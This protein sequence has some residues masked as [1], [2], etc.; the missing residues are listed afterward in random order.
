MSKSNI[1]RPVHYLDSRLGWSVLSENQKEI[2]KFG[3]DGM[4]Q[5][6][7]SAIIN[8]VTHFAKNTISISIDGGATW[9]SDSSMWSVY[10][11][12][13]NKLGDYYDRNGPLNKAIIHNLEAWKAERRRK[14]DKERR[15]AFKALA[16]EVQ[17][18]VRQERTAAWEKRKELAAERKAQ[19]TA[20]I[21]GQMLEIGPELVR[22]KEEIDRALALMAKGGLDSQ[23]PY[24]VSRRRYIRTAKWTVEDLS[25]HIN[26]A[27]KRTNK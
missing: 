24:Y 15:E 22:L 8:H 20:L 12:N 25:R 5:M 9:I 23:F 17:Q 13:A 4:Y 21:M 27:H 1:F 2:V 10:R 3:S 26:K 14:L 6:R 7:W 16:P 19:K 11:I 18:K